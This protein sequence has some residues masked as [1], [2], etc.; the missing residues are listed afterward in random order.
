MNIVSNSC[1]GA[2]LY[3]QCHNTFNN[4]FMWNVIDFDSFVY[5]IEHWNEIDFYDY[6]LIKDDKWIFS[7]LIEN[8]IKIQYVHYIFNPNY[9][10]PTLDKAGNIL[11]NKIWEYIVERYDTRLSRML[12]NKEYPLFCVCNFNTI[13]KDSIYTKEQLEK[14]STYKNVC[15]LNGCEHLNI[16]NAVNRVK[17]FLIKDIQYIR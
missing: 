9:S 16:H 4:P 13:Y 14:L 8:K 11:Y 7:I 15:I 12:D 17:S 10:H 3:K 6:E 2:C 1:I 5:L